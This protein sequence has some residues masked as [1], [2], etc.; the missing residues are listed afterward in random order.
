M[1]EEHL[2]LL[3]EAFGGAREPEDMIAELI[4]AGY[5]AVVDPIAP[6]LPIV[7]APLDIATYRAL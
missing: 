6:V 3:A 4:E 1:I 7:P 2:A 5:P